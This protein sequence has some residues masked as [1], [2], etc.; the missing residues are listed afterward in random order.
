MCL[1]R[2]R[3]QHT[4]NHIFLKSGHLIKINY[5]NNYYGSN[6]TTKILNLDLSV[7]RLQPIELASERL[8]ILNVTTMGVGNF[9][10]R[11]RKSGFFQVVAKGIS[12]EGQ[13]R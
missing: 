1:R 10:S 3:K 6:R 5:P 12:P 13:Q 4:I 8:N 2:F 11:E 7:P 9:F